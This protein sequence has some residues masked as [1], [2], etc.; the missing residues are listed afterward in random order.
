MSVA[1]GLSGLD[2]R[3]LHEYSVAD[4]RPRIEA[5]VTW[6]KKELSE[7]DGSLP[8]TLRSSPVRKDKDDILRSVPG[9]GE[10]LSLALLSQLPELGTLMERGGYARRIHSPLSGCQC[11]RT[12]GRR[13][14][15]CQ[16]RS[17][18]SL[19]FWASHASR[20]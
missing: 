18:N 7:T 11:G 14:G 13:C 12:L 15:A 6:L 10:S 1:G 9:V 3:C 2:G 17:L 20:G 8:Q 19:T 16:G 5:Y 4:V